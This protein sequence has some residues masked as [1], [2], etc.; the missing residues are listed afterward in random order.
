M[1]RWPA[2]RRFLLGAASVSGTLLSR[3]AG[4][5]SVPALDLRDPRVALEAYVKLRGSTA[6]ETVFQ[7]YE[8]DI[9]LVANG[10]IGIP[11]CG[12]A[13]IQKSVWR[14][15]GAGGFRNLDY[16][17]GF[18]VDYE[19]RAILDRWRNPLT[20]RTVQVHHYRGG[21]SGGRFSTTSPEDDV[22]GGVAGR[23]SIAGEQLCHTAA[24][25]GV[26][27][28]PMSPA[29]WPLASSGPTL[30]GSMSL[31]FCGRLPDVLDAAQAAPRST[32]FWTNV[33]AWM[34]WM[35]M[36]QRPGFNFWRWIGA[37]GLSRGELPAHLV[38][39][40]AR[41]WP[42]FVERDEPWK[43][44]TSGRLDYMRAKQGLPPTR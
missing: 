9:F 13:G 38:E 7:A 39:A 34:P 14:R 33:T 37:K 44:P 36:G 24:N 22:Y 28:N 25:W 41:A 21:P 3:A 27:P 40:C 43:Q 31:S 35:E 32:Q 4:A 16:D 5:A 1:M 42:G 20:G 17:L 30:L 12:F 2:R 19:S 15:D 6:D 10:E 11:L 18:Y 29:D 23:W 26:R 8:G